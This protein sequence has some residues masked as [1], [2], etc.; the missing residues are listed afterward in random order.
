MSRP[1]QNIV[2]A[3]T[4]RYGVASS[5]GRNC[6]TLRG[7]TIRVVAFRAF[8]PAKPPSRQRELVQGFLKKQK[9]ALFARDGLAISH[10]SNPEQFMEN[11]A[12]RWR[13]YFWPTM[14]LN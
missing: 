6:S 4:S 9:G 2:G 8:H 10:C 14:T 11:S 5:V 13:A 1:R 12:K 7:R 3:S